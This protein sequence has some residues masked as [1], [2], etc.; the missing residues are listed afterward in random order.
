[1]LSHPNIVVDVIRAAVKAVQAKTA[2][3]LKGAS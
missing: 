1:M 2:A 3:A